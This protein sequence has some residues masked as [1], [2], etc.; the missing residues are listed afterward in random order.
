M[1]LVFSGGVVFSGEVICLRGAVSS[2]VVSSGGASVG[3]TCRVLPSSPNFCRARACF[4]PSPFRIAQSSLS[5][6]TERS[7]AT[8]ICSAGAEAARSCSIA[9]Y[10][11]RRQF[12]GVSVDCDSSSSRL[13]TLTYPSTVELRDIACPSIGYIVDDSASVVNKVIILVRTERTASNAPRHKQ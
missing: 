4:S 3:L 2:E 12:T 1:E 8:S 11:V 6:V 7:S 9:G 13:Q 5:R 10:R